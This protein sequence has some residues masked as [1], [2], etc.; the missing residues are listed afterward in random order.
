MTAF[1]W[2][3][4]RVRD[5]LGWLPV[6]ERPGRSF[7]GV[8]TDSR[9]V[10]EGDLFVALVGERFDGHDYVAEAVARG[11]AGVV[12]SRR[13]DAGDAKV[14]PV[15]DTLRALGLLARYRRRA[16]DA[17]V[18]G[19]TGSAGKT[20][21][22]DMTRGA[23]AT[24][25]CVHATRGNLNNQIGV[26][27][28]ILAA[29][30][31]AEVLV[32][33]MGTNEPGE[34]EILAAIA[35]PEIGVVTTVSETHVEK[36]GSLEGVLAEKLALI[37]ALPEGGAALVGDEPAELAS[38][39]SRIRADVRVAG[40]SHR[41]DPE[42]RPDNLSVDAKG[43][44]RFDWRDATVTL[45]V[46]GRHNLGNALLALA[47]AEILGV[48]PAD[49]ARGVSLVGPAAMRGEVRTVG[50][51]T[52]IVDCYNANPQSVRAALDLLDDLRTDAGSV[53]VLG[54]MLELG[55][56]S[57]GLH[58]RLLSEALARSLDLLVATGDF[59][60]AAARLPGAGD[61]EAE[62]RLLVVPEPMDAYRDL[63]ARLTAGQ[64]LLLKGSRGVRLE[65]LL[66][67][68]TQDFGGEG[69]VA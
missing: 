59:A 66:E 62:G 36:L 28:T 2:T 14:Y 68:L 33:E 51:L 60:A 56:L 38:E 63:A 30:D 47:V 26:P 41:A 46:P 34:I 69:E 4:A 54:S 45:S 6:D 40:P 27:L 20:T 16:L 37:S 57:D 50:G 53:A 9:Q 10:G 58:D 17:R 55:D 7:R 44:A 67:P 13:V 22:K 1:H 23:L 32:V 19:I 21:T 42:L 5:A 12:V 39:A 8:T 49:A 61:A 31:E 15:S 48:D 65:R 3:D 18:V 11:A 25:R 35:E 52:V 43:R 29:P 64:T 24:G